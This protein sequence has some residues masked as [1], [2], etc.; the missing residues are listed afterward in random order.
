M[1]VG[2]SRRNTCLAETGTGDVVLLSDVALFPVTGMAVDLEGK[3]SLF[4][5]GM[6]ISTRGMLRSG[7]GPAGMI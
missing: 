4:A 7:A 3:G 1:N 2:G 6:C 5:G